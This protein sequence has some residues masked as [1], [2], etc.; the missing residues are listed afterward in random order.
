VLQ[1]GRYSTRD[2]RILARSVGCV[3]PTLDV[4]GATM[5]NSVLVETYR[6]IEIRAVGSQK[7]R[8]YRIEES[9]AEVVDYDGSNGDLEEDLAPLAKKAKK[10]VEWSSEGDTLVAICPDVETCR[11]IIDRAYAL[12]EE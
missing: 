3:P 8:R 12:V 2:Y 6:D 9:V 1:P 7:Q 4:V 5:K 11:W 10:Q